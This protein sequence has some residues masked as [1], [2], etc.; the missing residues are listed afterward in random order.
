MM[1]YMLEPVSE[2]ISLKGP[3]GDFVLYDDSSAPVLLLAFGDGI[4]PIKSLTEHAISVDQA[5]SFRLYWIGPPAEEN[6]LDRL[7]R[8]WNDSLDNFH[9]TP[10]PGEVG[11]A[12]QC[13]HSDLP[14]LR[15]FNIYLAG[16]RSE[17]EQGMELLRGWGLDGNLVRT[18]AMT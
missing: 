11:E 8:S 4:A 14:D 13:L 6:Y 15:P 17:L 1:R 18:E 10:L 2:I 9:F 12:M 3:V 7:C 5:E 16:P